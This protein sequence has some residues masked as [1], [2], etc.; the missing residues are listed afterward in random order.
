MDERRMV[1]IRKKLG[2]ANMVVV[3]CEEKG[4]NCGVVEEWC[5]LGSSKQIKVSY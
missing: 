3:D 4:G 5:R 1:T 2:M